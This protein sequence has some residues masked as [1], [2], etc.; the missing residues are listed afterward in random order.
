M[1]NRP[2]AKSIA[3]IALL[4]AAP[5]FAHPGHEAIG[6]GVFASLAAG[7]THPLFGLDHLAAMLI[8]GVWARQ[9]GGR[10]QLL[11]P[12]SF[13]ALMLCGAIAAQAGVAVPAVES[14]IA[15]SLVVLG[16]LCA[17]ALR[18]PS[19]A[20]AALVAT[21]AIFHGAAHGSEL[22]AGSS[23]VAFMTGFCIATALLHAF[24]FFAAAGLQGRA[25][26]TLRFGGLA[27]AGLG[28]AMAWI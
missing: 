6:S 16:L 26:L 15:A 3:G 7:F 19:L 17:T 11:V 24:G 9:L 22:P 23:P 14:G 10:A 12:L 20:A 25:P 18:L 8:V 27:T 28:L 1:S 4:T 5:A 13:V 21:F 2:L